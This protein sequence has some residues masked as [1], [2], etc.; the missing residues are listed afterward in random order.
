MSEQR[1]YR[2]YDFV[3][4]GFVTV[5]ICSNEDYYDRKTNFNP[6]TLKA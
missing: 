2:Y 6:F 3:M 1:G 5:L 4:A